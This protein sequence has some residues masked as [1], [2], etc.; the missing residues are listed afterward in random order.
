MLGIPKEV[1]YTVVTREQ[2]EVEQRERLYRG[3]RLAYDVHGHTVILVD[4]GIA[5]GA[6]MRAAVAAVRH[7]QPA[8]IIIAVPV[9][10]SAT[11]EE[12][13]AEVDELVCIRRP[14]M[15]FAVGFWYEH[16]SQ[17]SDK[18][19]A[20]V[21]SSTLLIVGDNDDVVLQVNRSE[22]L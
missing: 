16:F 5:T 18:V 15:F 17:T 21:K 3:D 14:K 4:D 19:L 6:T 2:Q 13:V 7:Q 11:C 20:Q 22:V 8:R 10:A 9:A 12:F 1:I